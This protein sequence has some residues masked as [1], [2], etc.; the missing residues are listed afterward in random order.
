MLQ[1][2]E[3]TRNDGADVG[4][5][6]ENNL[7]ENPNGVIPQA[8]LGNF[9]V[10][11][12]LIAGFERELA[13]LFGDIVNARKCQLEEFFVTIVVQ[14]EEGLHLGFE[15]N[16]LVVVQVGAETLLLLMP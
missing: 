7:E 14:E 10:E 13:V 16:V 4:S 11:V 1:D 2:S 6:V 9:D 12:H 3:C 5:L 15:D 8:S